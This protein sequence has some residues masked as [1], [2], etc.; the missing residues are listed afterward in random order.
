MTVRAPEQAD[1]RVVCDAAGVAIGFLAG[2]GLRTDVAFEFAV[3]DDLPAPISA[4]AFGGYLRTEN[5]AYLLTSSRVAARGT[6]FGLAYDR[7]LYRVLAVHEIAHAVAAANFSVPQPSLEAEEYI[8][9]AAMFATMPDEARRQVLER[10]GVTLQSA[11]ELNSAVY[12]L[13]PFRYGILAYLHFT[14]PD[15]GKAFLRDVLA[16]RALMEFAF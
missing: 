15:G 2:Q 1:A 12:L 5:R 16:G 9:Y 6:V 7:T 8:A 4:A 13:D 3:V 11:L 14:G 10:S